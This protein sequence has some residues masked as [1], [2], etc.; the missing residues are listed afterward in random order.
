VLPRLILVSTILLTAVPLSGQR[1]PDSVV[2]AHYELW[3]APD[4]HTATF[5]GR[6]TI[7]VD[8]RQPSR[9]ITL[10]A[11]EITF[12]SVRVRAG[13]VTQVASV[14]TNEPLEQATFT[15]PRT[16]GAGPV[17]IEIT[18][19]G[20]LNDKLRGFYLSKTA[21]R[22]Y[23]VSQMEATDA[24]RA[25][26]SF[27]EPAFKA[28]F[29]V[30]LMIDR[31][32]VAI[33]N[34]R[35]IADTPGPDP[36]K[37]TMRFATTKKMSTYLVA[38]VV[39][40]FK[41]R[42]G[43]A[44]GTPVRVCATPD[45]TGLTSY[46]LDAAIREVKFFNQYFGIR[47]PF[48][49]L[50]LVAIPDFAA[51]AME[52]AGAILFRERA[53]LAD[54]AQSAGAVQRTLVENT[55]HEIAHQWF[56]NLVT[57]RWWDDLWLNEGFATWME[58]KATDALEPAWHSE[59]SVEQ[60]RQ[61]ALA[62][63]ALRSTRPI[64]A[65][66]N[67]PAEINELF[68]AIAYEKTAVVLRMIEGYVGEEAFKRGVSSYLRRFAYG[69]ATGQDFWSEMTSVTGKPVDRILTT[70]VDQPG[71]PVVTLQTSCSAGTT[72]LRIGQE[73]F[74]AS[75]A[76]AGDGSTWTFPLCIKTSGAPRCDVIQQRQQT[77]TFPG[78][79]AA[80]AN[81][82]SRGYY[83]TEYAGDTVRAFGK[84]FRELTYVERMGLLGDEWWM[85][86]AGRHAIDV[87]LDVA[88]A[89]S[90]DDTAAVVDVIAARLFIVHDRL[91]DAADRARL[92]QWI[93]DRY[94]PTLRRL[95]LP[96]AATDSENAQS[97]R[98][99]LLSLV[100]IAGN[101]AAIQQRALELARRYMN[102]RGAVPPTLAPAVLQVAAAGDPGLYDAYLARL[103]TLESDPEEYY[104]YFNALP[105]FR[106]PA[107]VARTL[108]FSLSPGAR[109]QDA[110]ALL[111]A[112]MAVP[113]GREQAWPF[114]QM[115]WSRLLEKL[116]PAEGLPMLVNGL[117]AYCAGARAEEVR[118]FF[119][120]H[121]VEGLGRTVDQQVEEIRS[122][123]E[124]RDRAAPVIA[125]WL[126]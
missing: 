110:P 125:R 48:E 60:D 118:A 67:T 55:A 92:E 119:T 89:M 10:N 44:D 73:R 3:F 50:D 99:T 15:V 14:T 113:W 53:L 91:V 105:W 77:L 109:S 102:D 122:C 31:G 101:D 117:G 71:A 17:T 114:V 35:Q 40:D 106:D 84:N 54:P 124:L 21:S 81:P 116:D 123:A 6:E 62:V 121:A 11:A 94:G 37:H 45:K 115:Q 83:L 76:A 103:A 79:Q 51:F 13:T 57:M 66:V 100:G 27:D 68:D 86:R 74:V 120:T 30:S 2:P 95:G 49:K 16:L 78:C 46:A 36:D 33:S 34:G 4:L 42:E 107:L 75:G 8:L 1:L 97:L 63:D 61:R 96:G 52:N 98:A 12:Q 58:T 65:S 32:D 7:R 22:A 20:L 24:R 87:F 82:E 9:T 72:T 59:L 56:G 5:R 80:F 38:L 104:R 70:L 41:C 88:S 126:H 26:P 47:Y 43:S 108:T 25:F 29:D 85:A 90:D 111:A 69:N 112:L 93:R 19:T 28:T 64:H 39:G 18:Y 23:A